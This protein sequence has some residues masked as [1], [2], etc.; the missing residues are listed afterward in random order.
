MKTFG[1]LLQASK[2]AIIRRWL[3]D[4]LATY[5]ED[6]SVAFG[7]RKDQFANPVGHSLRV[8]TRAIFEAL[9][10][11]FDA[12]KIRPPLHEIVKIRAVQQFSPSTAVG[13]IFLLKRAVR[14]ELGAPGENPRLSSERAQFEERIDRL[15]LTAFDVFV[16][17][18]ERVLE[19]R[20]NE[21]KRQ[22]PWAVSRMNESAAGPEPACVEQ[23]CGVTEA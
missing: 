19:L 7:R 17:C 16:E 13:F 6:A 8:G 9:L 21:L 22:I 12:A 2:D 10:E 23:K 3:D 20:V 14:L 18:R 4:V 15:A 11:G 5:S 1:E